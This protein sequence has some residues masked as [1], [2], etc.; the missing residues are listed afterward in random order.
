MRTMR[1]QEYSRASSEHPDRC[2]DA[3]LA[4]NPNGDRTRYAPMFAVIDGLGGHQHNGTDG[5]ITGY[6]VA[7]MI[8]IVLIEDLEHLPAGIDGS[9]DGEAEQRITT[10][11]TRANE[12]VYRELNCG[13]TFP[14]RERVG[15]VVTVCVLAE[16]GKRMVSMQVGD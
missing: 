14:S 12:R 15:A 13:G 6:D 2:E 10:A 5:T 3:L 8:R 4:F 7:Q 16:N 1:V 9:P 11:L